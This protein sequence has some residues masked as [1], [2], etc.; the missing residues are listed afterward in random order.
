LAVAF[1]T[2]LPLAFIFG[3]CYPSWY[4]PAWLRAAA[5]AFPLRP[6]AKSIELAF[7]PHPAGSPFN[8]YRAGIVAAWVVVAV[9]VALTDFWWDPAAAWRTWRHGRRPHRM[10]WRACIGFSAACSPGRR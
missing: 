7:D 9:A 1:G 8:L 10:A 3:V 6:L 2:M 4:G 5:D